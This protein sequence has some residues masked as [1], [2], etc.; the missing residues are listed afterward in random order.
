MR[1]VVVTEPGGPEAMSWTEVPDP[2]LAPGEILIDV[3]ATAVNRADV[4]QRQGFYPPPPGASEILGLE[5]SGTVAAL[6]D[7]VTGFDIGDEVCALLTG[8][9]YAEKVAVPFGQ[10]MPL[11]PGVDT[12]PAASIPEVACTVWSNLVDV[13][14]V[15]PG[16]LVL[17]H[18]GAGGIGTHAIQV[19]TALGARVAVTAGNQT[20][21]D[22]CAE[23]GADICIN[24]RE[25]DFVEVIKREAGGADVVL[26]NMGA[27]YLERNVNVLAADGRI[28]V[29]GLQGGIKT[30]LNLSKLL[31]KRGAIHATS[32]RGRP[33]TQKAAICD[34]VVA[35][36]WPMFAAGSVRPIVDSVTPISEV[37]H[38]HERMEASSHVG[39]IVL[40]V[41]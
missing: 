31:T 12:L 3:A 9:G 8:G 40:A 14:R 32:L 16:E 34:E 5:C 39:K 17:L 11:P 24:Y 25:Q 37:A 20:K 28:V 10:V 7:D 41:S 23:L 38:A 21:L 27:K 18:G 22:L 36:V 35:N 15:Q 26:D 13:A 2:T 6:A 29:I 19:C 1:A 30:E 4:L 33:V